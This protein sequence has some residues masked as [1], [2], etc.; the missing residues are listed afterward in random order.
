MSA[1]TAF[2]TRIPTRTGG[3]CASAGAATHTTAKTNS[4]PTGL[5]NWA[6]AAMIVDD[7]VDDHTFAADG[8]LPCWPHLM[9]SRRHDIELRRSG[10]KGTPRRGQVENRYERLTTDQRVTAPGFAPRFDRVHC[11]SSG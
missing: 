5:S 8:S 11:V 1:A 2:T 7:I 4:G 3:V 10:D 9:S 6:I